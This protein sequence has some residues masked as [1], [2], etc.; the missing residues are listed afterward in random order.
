MYILYNFDHRN[1]IFTLL[2][3][4][5]TIYFLIESKWFHLQCDYEPKRIALNVFQI[6]VDLDNPIQKKMYILVLGGQM[7]ILLY[8]NM[9]SPRE[10]R[11]AC[12]WWNDNC[13]TTKIHVLWWNIFFR[14]NLAAGDLNRQYKN[15]PR[16]PFPT[17]YH[18]KEEISKILGKLSI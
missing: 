3:L 13:H 16:D 9:K 2:S 11:N 8:M 10:F 1:I 14:C 15:A 18:V 6:N 12:L 5:H 7:W 4:N 17:V